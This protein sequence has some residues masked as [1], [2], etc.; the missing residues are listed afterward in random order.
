MT[1]AFKFDEEAMKVVRELSEY[2]GIPVEEVL[3]KAVGLMRIESVYGP[4]YV[5]TA[6]GEHVITLEGIDEIHE[7]PVSEQE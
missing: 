1:A 2:H 6:T 7:N 3:S 5:K 4:L